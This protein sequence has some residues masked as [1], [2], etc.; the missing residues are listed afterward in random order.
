MIIYDELASAPDRELYDVLT[1]S[2]GARDNPLVLCI[3]TAGYDRHSILYELYAHACR[4]KENPSL[5]PTFLPILY[6]MEPD[7]DWTDIHSY[8]K[9]N[10]ALGDFRSLEE[11][12]IAIDRAKQ[13]PAQENTLRRLYG[14]Q[15]TE[16]A[17]RWIQ[18]PAWD[19]CCVV[20]S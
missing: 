19:A 8:K 13:I 1:T 16:Q 15:W 11:L 20:T 7:A 2:T 4:V 17:D 18:M 5:D 10:P 6:E 9:C 14:N 12:T 3:S